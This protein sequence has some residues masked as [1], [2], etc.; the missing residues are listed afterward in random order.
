MKCNSASSLIRLMNCA[1]LSDPTSISQS[2]TLLHSLVSANSLTPATGLVPIY[3]AANNDSPRLSHHSCRAPAQ[4]PQ[5]GPAWPSHWHRR[6]PDPTPPGSSLPL[7]PLRGRVHEPSPPSRFHARS[8]VRDWA[9][10]AR[11]TCLS[12]SWER[13]V[14]PVNWG[15]TNR[16]RRCR[17][18]STTGGTFGRRSGGEVVKDGATQLRIAGATAERRDGSGPMPYW[19]DEM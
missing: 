19:M 17:K 5:D 16:R 2:M 11:R 12:C 1:S 18:W 6:A 10:V 9:S 13:S 4:A 8:C 3:A 15:Y 14:Y 7:L